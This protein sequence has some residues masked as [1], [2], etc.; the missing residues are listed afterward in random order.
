M[1]PT[2]RNRQRQN[3]P[4]GWANHL[5]A[6]AKYRK[7]QAHKYKAQ[8][9]VKAAVKK[10]VL[11]R[12]EHCYVPDC[13]GTKIEAHHFDYSTPL[14]VTWLCESCHKQ[15]HKEARQFHKLK[16]KK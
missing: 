13:N 12:P 6:V 4:E 5:K 3:T 10:G 15:V 2:E 1:S 14:C 9:E 8:R 7:E 16:E 11:V